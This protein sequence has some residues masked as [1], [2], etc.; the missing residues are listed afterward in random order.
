ME[1][2]V[3]SAFSNLKF[4]TLALCRKWV[5]VCEASRA[6]VRYSSNKIVVQ[7]KQLKAMNKS[8]INQSI[9]FSQL[10]LENWLLGGISSKSAI[11]WENVCCSGKSVELASLTNWGA[12]RLEDAGNTNTKRKQNYN[13]NTKI[14]YNIVVDQRASLISFRSEDANKSKIIP[15][16]KLFLLQLLWI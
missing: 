7:E 8:I 14:Q 11:S 15:W 6:S 9:D 2:R 16:Q 5:S 1:Q 4:S 10:A 12:S 3:W 13:T